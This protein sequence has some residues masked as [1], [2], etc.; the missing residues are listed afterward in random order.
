MSTKRQFYKKSADMEFSKLPLAIIGSMG[1]GVAGAI[2][3]EIV[4][5]L[6]FMF[7]IIVPALVSLLMSFPFYKILQ[8]CKCRI[9][10]IIA[11]LAVLMGTI[12]YIGHYQLDLAYRTEWT[13]LFRIDALFS[14]LKLRFST[15]VISHRGHDIESSGVMNI[16]TFIFNYVFTCLLP[17]I[18][19]KRLSDIPYD[20]HNDD[21]FD[22]KCFPLYP[23]N[24]SKLTNF[25]E[26]IENNQLTEVPIIAHETKDPHEMTL[27][28][29]FPPKFGRTAGYFEIRELD[30]V[31]VTKNREHMYPKGKVKKST[32]IIKLNYTQ[33]T[34]A[35]NQLNAA[36]KTA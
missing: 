2:I 15:D 26:L 35:L 12:A 28:T 6:G 18:M 36:G 5:S 29:L 17:I 14:Y 27:I 11:A 23:G 32:G 22:V 19:G 3:L 24:F 10:P 4:F 9:F 21:W 34:S 30:K 1:L 13:N 31:N 8:Y 7:L 25:E 20:E 33:L 16:I